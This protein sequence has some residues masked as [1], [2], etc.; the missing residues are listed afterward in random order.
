MH[1][2]LPVQSFRLRSG[3]ASTAQLMN[4]VAQAL[5]PDAKTPVIVHRISGPKSHATPGTG[6]IRG[7]HTFQG[8]VFTVS[9]TSLYKVDIAGTETLIGSIPGSGSVSMAHNPDYLVIVAE[10]NGYYSD[11]STVTQITDADFTARGAKYV[12]F[13]DNFLLFTEPGTGRFFWADVGS[14]VNFDS[15]NF[16]TAEGN[17]DAANGIISDH[18]QVI[19][20]GEES[21]ELFD[22]TSDGF[23]RSINGIIEIGCFN[24]DTVQKFDNSVAWVAND[25]TV[26]KLEGTTP[27]KISDEGVEVFLSTAD[28]STLKAYAYDQ[29]GKFFYLVC[30]STGCFA[31]EVKA[32]KWAERSTYPQDYFNWQYHCKAHGRQYVGDFYSNAICYFDPET[33]TDNG[34]IQR[35]SWTYQP[36]YAENETAVHDSLE[37]VMEVGVGLVLG[38]GSNPEMMMAYSD[39]GGKTWTNLPNRTMGKMGKYRKRVKWT[40]IGSSPQRVYRGAV[41]DPVP[42]T[43]N[44]TIIRGKGGRL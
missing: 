6:P 20:F 9:G 2:H 8:D 13:C 34:G 27:R 14:A 17:P 15:L 5:P 10:P 7:M 19:V 38:Q 25:Y 32:D 41:S 11:G 21:V 39:D 36:I 29:D 33:Y 16:T 1:L 23:Q 43:I 22:A 28:V 24:G 44:D 31:Y 37:V 40:S 35:M 18:G 12:T 3:P 4:C 26:R 30:C 42:I